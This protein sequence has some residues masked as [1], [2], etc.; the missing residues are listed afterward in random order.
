M[1]TTEALPYIAGAKLLYSMIRVSDLERS[2]DFYCNKLGM[3]LQRTEEYPS[4]GFTLAFVGYGDTQEA[5]IELTYNWDDRRYQHGT[6]F[7]HLAIGVADVQATSAALAA[8]GVPILREP[9]PML[10]RPRHSNEAEHIAFVA[11]P[12]GYRIELV[13][14]H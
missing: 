13:Q 5:T 12:D 2:L 3:T 10:H 1:R 9:G 4:G 11:D 8:M 14:Q 6:S 7:G